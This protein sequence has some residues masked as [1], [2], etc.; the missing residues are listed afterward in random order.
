M[1]NDDI[2]IGQ[3]A[4]ELTRQKT[5]EILQTKG[6]SIELTLRRLKQALN[7]KVTKTQLDIKTG[8]FLYSK[9]LVDNST[10]LKAVEVSLA[11]YGAMPAKKHEIAGKD[12]GPITIE[13]IKFAESSTTE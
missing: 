10:R 8:E 5:L 3:I 2:K 11:L 4:N 12:G 6:P 1:E 7:A 9:D 13:V